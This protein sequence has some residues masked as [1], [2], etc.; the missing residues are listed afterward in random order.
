MAIS[1]GQQRLDWY[2][3]PGVPLTIVLDTADGTDWASAPIVHVGPIDADGD[4]TPVI[5][6]QT[7]TITGTA[8]RATLTLTDAQ[9]AA[10]L[11]AYPV[12]ARTACPW[13]V[14]LGTGESELAVS[15]G[16]LAWD[17]T[18]RL[19]T[20]SAQLVVGPP[21]PTAVS[22]DPGNA[23]E[24]GSDSLLFVGGGAIATEVEAYLDAN[25]PAAAT[26]L[27]DVADTPTRVAMTPAERTKLAGVAA[28]ATANAADAQLRDRATHTGTQSSASLSDLT[29]TV[30]DIV[31]A[32]IVAGTNVAVTYDDVAGTFTIASTAVLPT[33]QV[34]AGTGLSGGGDL[35]ADRTLAV[36]YGTTA[37][38]AAQGNDSRITGAAQKASNLSDLGSVA[39]AR[40]NLGLGTAAVANTGTGAANVILG[41]DTRLTN[42]RTPTA[43]THPS[44]DLSDST[45]T[46]RAVLTAADAASAR[47]AI[48]AGTLSTETLPATLVD[49]KGDLIVGTAADTPA[50]LAVGTDGHVLTADA[51]QPGGVKWA[52]AAGGV[53]ESVATV[54]LSQRWYVGHGALLASNRLMPMELVA[55]PFVVWRSVTIDALSVQ[56]TTAA[57]AGGYARL[58]IYNSAASGLPGT[59][60]LD[61]GTVA[62]TSTGQKIITITPR[63]LT[64]GV[65]YWLVSTS[66]TADC[67]AYGN[68]NAQYGGS[69]DIGRPDLAG[70]SDQVY[71]ART[72]GV[73]DGGALVNL[74]SVSVVYGGG[75]AQVG[76][77]VA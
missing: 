53:S 40:T 30:Q 12:A 37:G 6:A 69:Q 65:V 38:S 19:V 43:H 73:G 22:A 3:V 50:R 55:T 24:L 18:G 27:D 62:T 36:S 72:G 77:R 26:D 16:H 49:A 41:N 66:G 28:G 48:G 2:A 5:P 29:E 1:G 46:G 21:G 23:A 59:V 58:G 39:T 20:T 42:A 56:V 67:L 54:Y 74:T 15:T 44:T 57:T 34:I 31:A 47:A 13:H 25:P 51:T 60:L 32:L 14:R 63:V 9:M 71:Y 64:P 11:T 70:R 10:I 8:S 33:R 76:V 52:A 7:A 75:Y 17:T 4:I 68:Q 35:S 45:T 61:A